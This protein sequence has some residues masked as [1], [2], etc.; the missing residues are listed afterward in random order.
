MKGKN[1]TI[2]VVM[3]VVAL[4]AAGCAPAAT[5]TPKPVAPAATATPKPAPPAAT[6]T[7]EP[8]PPV[9]IGAALSTTGSYA[10][11]AAWHE[12]AYTMWAEEVNAAGGLLGREVQLIMYDDESDPTKTTSLYERLIT[13]DNVDLLLGPYSSACNFP[14]QAIAEQYEMVFLISGGTSESLYTRGF[15]YSFCT[16]PGL[17]DVYAD[18][19]FRWLQAN[20]PEE[21]RPKSIAFLWED[22][23]FPESC[24]LGAKPKAEAMG[25]EVVLEEKYAAGT[26][27]FTS[28]IA[29]AKAAG[30]EVLFGGTY[31]PDSVGLVSTSS[32]LDYCPKA[33]WMSVGPSEPEFGTELGELANYV[34]CGVHWEPTSKLP[35]V[36]EFLQKYSARWGRDPDYHAA[37]AYTSCEILQQ[38]VE[39]TGS[40]DNKV[41]RDYIS[42]QT[43]DTVQGELSFD[44]RGVPLE[45][46]I[47]I[48]WQ[49][50]QKEVVEPPDA[51]T[52]EA[53]YP[54][55]CWD[56]R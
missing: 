22:T 50:G 51:S 7:P 1:S 27:D 46:M 13:A 17:A 43:F 48:Q 30:A 45:A 54:M 23:L 8:L 34:W 19:F 20:V 26:T 39:G 2:F 25:M 52:G 12:E 44:E 55:P 31:F 14:A 28:L 3:L 41:L 9:V 4:L 35:G 18:G 29:K 11:S 37:R 24:V 10:K 47:Q 33:I 56:E 6:A 40:F 5:P 16:A 32:E 15:I 21:E 53:I 49:N 38:A 42:T 36:E